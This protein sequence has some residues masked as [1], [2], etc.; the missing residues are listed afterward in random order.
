MLTHVGGQIGHLALWRTGRQVG[1][2]Q[3]GFGYA[4]GAARLHHR[5]IG[6]EQSH[7]LVRRTFDDFVQ[8]RGQRCKRRQQHPALGGVEH[9]LPA[10]DQV[11]QALAFFGQPGDAIEPDDLQCAVRLMQMHLAKLDLRRGGGVGQIGGHRHA[12]LGQGLLD[13]SFDPGQGSNI[14]FR[15]CAHL[16]HLYFHSSGN[17]Q[18]IQHRFFNLHRIELRR[19][20]AHHASWRHATLKPDTEAFNSC[21]SAAS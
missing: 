1:K 2:K 20:L 16:S 17:L 7:R 18:P 21:A 6:R 13:F 14:K 19:L 15:R 3:I 9:D 4:F 10:L 8:V 12:G 11:E 5:L